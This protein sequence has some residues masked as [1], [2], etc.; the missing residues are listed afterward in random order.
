MLPQPP[1]PHT[2]KVMSRPD[3]CRHYLRAFIHTYRDLPVLWDTSMRDYTNREK[4]AEAYLR[5]VPIYHYLKR[6]AT[7]E[8]VKKKINTLRTNYR[9]E[10]KVMESALRSG[11]HHSPRCWTFQELD[12]L[13]NSEKFLA[14][15]PFFKNEPSFL[16]SENSSCSTA[17]LDQHGN[18]QQ[19]YPTPRGAGGQT[20]NINISEMFHKSFGH[21]Q[22]VDSLPP[23]SQPPPGIG[24][25]DYGPTKR[26]RQTP[27]LNNGS[28]GGSAN[29]D[30]LN[31][32][33][34]YLA[35]TYPDEE[36]ES[37]ARTWTHKL[38]RLPREQRLLAERF[39]NEILFEAESNNLHRGSL[40]INNSFEPY[41]R[42][43]EASAGQEEQDKSQSPSVHTSTESKAIVAAEAAA[44]EAAAEAAAGSGLPL[45]D[46]PGATVEIREF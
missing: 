27:P 19:H 10:L 34:E 23:P 25:S 40:Q 24:H 45:L 9:K 39:I 29:T 41:V 35:G 46:E 5:L 12:F 3:E 32:A 36:L 37:I 18:P 6:D 38:R 14:V 16:F 31:I 20:P 42:Y 1:P 4:R 13:R 22:R 33:C 15:N 43:D 8:D 11:T 44:V 26:A 17:F 30:E 2:F 28:G 21:A 7:V